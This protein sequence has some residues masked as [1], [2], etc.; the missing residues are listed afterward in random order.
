MKNTA[1]SSAAAALGSVK[2]EAKTAAA[3]KNGKLGGRPSYYEIE[4]RANAAL[5]MLA[6]MGGVDRRPSMPDIGRGRVASLAYAANGKFEATSN[7][8]ERDYV[9]A[10]WIAKNI[11]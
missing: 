10:E 4:R 8:G 9:D 5:R 7:S 11:D 3:R 2:S 1:I 6:K